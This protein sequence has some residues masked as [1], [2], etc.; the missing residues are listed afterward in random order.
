MRQPPKTRKSVCACL[1]IADSS[2]AARPA[3]KQSAWGYRYE[4][5]QKNT[6]KQ[7]RGRA[8]GGRKNLNVKFQEPENHT[9]CVCVCVCVLC[10]RCL[11]LVLLVVSHRSQPVVSLPRRCRS[12][13]TRE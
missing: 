8:G 11:L 3:H 9:V 13:S 2:E 1:R 4:P 10:S 6:T 7:A 5:N 12:T